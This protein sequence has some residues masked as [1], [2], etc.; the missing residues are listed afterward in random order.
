MFFVMHFI[1]K[2]STEDTVPHLFFF[3]DL[4]TIVEIITISVMTPMTEPATIPA[5]LDRPEKRMKNCLFVF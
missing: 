5:I 1:N 2:T 3:L 4:S